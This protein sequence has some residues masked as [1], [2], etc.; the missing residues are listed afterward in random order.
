MSV[1]KCL[2]DTNLLIYCVAEDD[3]QKQAQARLL[4]RQ[5]IAEHRLVLSFQAVQEFLNAATRK[6]KKTLSSNDAL[7]F[8][9]RFLWPHCTIMPSITLYGHALDLQGRFQYSFYDSLMLAAA[10][11]ARCGTLY[12]E[13]LQHGQKVEGVEIINPFL[14][15]AVA[16]PKPK[17]ASA[18][19]KAKN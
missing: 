7:D 11:E 10:L 5:L 6:F 12:S 1:A 8:A 17:K 16:K 3:L 14:E 2:L 18:A 15:L 19:K 9:R 4:L 13:D